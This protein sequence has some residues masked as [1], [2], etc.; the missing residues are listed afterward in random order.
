[1]HVPATDPLRNELERMPDGER[2]ISDRRELICDLGG[3][4]AR[5]D[6]DDAL[7]RVAGRV[8]VVGDVRELGGEV[9]FARQRGAMGVGER[10]A[11][12]D[13]PGGWELLAVARDDD[14]PAALPVN[15]YHRRVGPD[16]D[17]RG[18][19]VIVEILSDLVAGR[20]AVRIARKRHPGHRAEPGR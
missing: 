7:P 8:A 9:L 16:L 2:D 10:P 6:D 18:D 12:G 19:G 4:V 17:S 11:R 14:E 13:D 1:V 15:A 20:V 3:G 5:P